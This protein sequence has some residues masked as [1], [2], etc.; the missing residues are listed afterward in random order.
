M[1]DEIAEQ[2]D[3]AEAIYA[4][5]YRGISVPQAAELRTK[6]READ[7]SFRIVKN[8]LTIRAAEKSQKPS[9]D[10]LKA[11]VDSG[12]TALTFIKGDPAVAA[13]ALDSFVKKGELLDFKGGTL[14]AETL[15]ADDIKRLARLPSRDQLDAQLAGVVASPITGLVRGL[16]SMIS[17]LAVALGQVFEQK[18][19]GIALEGNSGSSEGTAE[20]PAA[21]EATPA[22]TAPEEPG[23]EETSEGQAD[24]QQQDQEQEGGQ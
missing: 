12:P 15:T 19:S 5:D 18:N 20:E 9:S 23:A 8:T 3:S 16:G 1:I 10:Q 2:I 24:D 7:A 17:G 14:G 11:F 21:Q 22:E 13:K 4:I 6:L